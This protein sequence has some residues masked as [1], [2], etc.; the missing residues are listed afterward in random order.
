MRI[1]SI[2]L[3]AINLC[4]VSFSNAQDT[5]ADS[6]LSQRENRN[7]ELKDTAH[8]PLKLEQIK[9]FEGLN[10]YHPNEDF[11]VQAK[12]K[13]KIGKVFDMSTSSG[14]L[15]KYR[16]YGTLT[17][18][19]KGN[20]YK[21]AVYQSMKFLNHPI[22]KNMLFIPFTDLTNYETTYAGGRYMDISIIKGKTTTIDFNYCYNPY[23]AYT[24]GYNCP[25]PPLEN[26]LKI[27]IEA[28]EKSFEKH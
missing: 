27:K 25:I 19:I 24:T 23:C 28:G 14:M 8:S 3:L 22:Y 15:K 18:K 17:F 4:V 16:K 12:F 13:K 9:V 20:K 1:A 26:H 2:I 11:K 21:L 5:Y 6:I 7:T 10:F